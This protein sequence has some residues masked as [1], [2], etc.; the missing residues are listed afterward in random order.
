[1]KPALLIADSDGELCDL[2]SMFFTERGYEVEVAFDGLDC[3]EKLRRLGPVVLLLDLE[4]RWGGADGVLAWLREQ[5]HKSEVSVVLTSVADDGGNVPDDFDA[6]VV[7]YLTKP[8]AP[9]LLFEAVHTA[10]DE[11]RQGERFVRIR[12][13]GASAG[14]IG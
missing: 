5:S 4:L 10:V 7:S 13:A 9:E 3:L 12:N 8:F 14:I 6:P 2:Y 1:M 11:R